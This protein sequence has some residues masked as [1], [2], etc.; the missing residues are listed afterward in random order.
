MSWKVKVVAE[1]QP[2][3]QGT[4]TIQCRNLFET[5]LLVEIADRIC[6][7]SETHGIPHCAGATTCSYMFRTCRR[8]T[9]SEKFAST[10]GRAWRARR[11]RSAAMHSLWNASA[12]AP[13]R[14]IS[15]KL[16]AGPTTH[17]DTGVSLQMMGS[18]HASASRKTFPNISLRE[19]NTKASAA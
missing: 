16:P 11:S 13:G 8:T 2:N 7:T 18:S 6:R 4:K 9:G 5:Q 10:W 12:R 1:Y 15:M 3:S 14:D 19:V 17:F